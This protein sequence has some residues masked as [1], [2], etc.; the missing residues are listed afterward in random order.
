MVFALI[1]MVIILIIRKENLQIKNQTKTKLL[2]TGIIIA[3]HWF[4]FY[5]A[6]K[7]ANVSIALIC[8]SASAFFCSILEPIFHKRKIIWYELLFG[9]IVIV[10]ISIIFKVETQYKNGIIIGLISAFLSA[11]FSVI[12]GKFVKKIS[13]YTISFYEISGGLIFITLILLFTGK[14]TESFF[15]ISIADLGWL[16]ILSSVCTAYAFSAS[17]KVMK[18]LTPY[19]VMLTVNLEP[20]YGII[21]AVLIFKNSENMSPMFYVGAGI[22][23]LTI[24]I[25]G[26]L[27]NR[28]K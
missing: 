8:L 21:L 15:Q 3:L 26:I 10:G 28:K 18:V 11:L 19:T 24:V 14:F 23:L 5:E 9:V 22:I 20:V 25:N 6:I 13:P 2:L 17:I 12:N 7:T 16:L 1:M 27:K 4:T